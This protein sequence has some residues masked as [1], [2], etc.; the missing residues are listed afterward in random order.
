MEIKG[1][2]ENVLK[3]KIEGLE[4]RTLGYYENNIGRLTNHELSI[5]SMVKDIVAAV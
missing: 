1:G 2:L 3:I 5:K 4:N